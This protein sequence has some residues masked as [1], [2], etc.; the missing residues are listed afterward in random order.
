MVAMFGRGFDSR[1]L[2]KFANAGR[3]TGIVVS[4]K[5][6]WSGDQQ[7]RKV[8]DSAPLTFLRRRPVCSSPFYW[9]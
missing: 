1:R 9:W 2:H 3:L 8:S 5:Y 4:C 7:R 6:C